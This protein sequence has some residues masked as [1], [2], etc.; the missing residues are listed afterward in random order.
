MAATSPLKEQSAVDTTTKCFCK[1]GGDE[2]W[3]WRNVTTHVQR[4]KAMDARSDHPWY[5]NYF[6]VIIVTMF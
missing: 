5:H 3:G 6:Y 2:G 1:K 4:E